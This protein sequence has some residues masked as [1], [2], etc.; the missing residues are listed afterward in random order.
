MTYIKGNA[1][2]FLP[3]NKYF[4][5]FMQFDKLTMCEEMDLKK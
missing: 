2:D 1:A 3:G 4:P 5:F